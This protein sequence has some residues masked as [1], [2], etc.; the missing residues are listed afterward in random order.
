MFP[1][2]SCN[3]YQNGIENE[4]TTNGTPV[5][6]LTGLEKKCVYVYAGHS[7]FSFEIFV[8]STMKVKKAARQE[9]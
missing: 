5:C 9:L 6:T 7:N 8:L 2:F 4:A 3:S 1:N